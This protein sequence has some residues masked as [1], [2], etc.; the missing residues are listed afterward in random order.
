MSEKNL[1]MRAERLALIIRLLYERN[2]INGRLAT[3]H[4]GARYISFGIRLTDPM[5]GE[6]AMKLAEPLALASGARAV[7]AQRDYGLIV[8]QIQLPGGYWEYYTR[9]D[10]K[11]LEVGLAE[12]RRPVEFALDPP[13]ALVAGTTGAGKSETLKSILLAL[14]ESYTPAELRLILV[15]PH[16]DLYQFENEAHLAAPVANEPA[17]IQ[18]VL[19]WVGGELAHRKAE[20][21]RDGRVIVVAVDEADEALQ[22]AEAM[23]VCQ[24]IASQARKYNIHLILATQRPLQAKLP[25]ILDKLLNRWVGQLADAGTSARVTGHAGLEAHKLTPRGDFLHIAAPEVTRCQI[26]MARPSDFDRLERAEI[27][28]PEP[29]AQGVIEL[30]PV[31]E[32]SNGGRP[33]VELDPALL[34]AYWH[35]GPNNISY[36]QADKLLGLKR[37]G[38]ILH[39][40]FA[41]AM[42]REYMRLRKSGATL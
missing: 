12:Q 27:R 26:A 25:D 14:V 2:E 6:K 4:R 22:D 41:L 17:D 24:Q 36:S 15:D 19:L 30:P 1:S 11:G 16:A 34:A 21:I 33:P 20:N 9:A 7:I 38:H 3:A 10:V 35:Y 8:Y 31:V 37:T 5:Q 39:R 32:P 23:A 40:D 18:S 28:S 13:H 42:G 29:A